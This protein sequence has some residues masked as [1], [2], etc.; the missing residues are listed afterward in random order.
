[1]IDAANGVVSESTDTIKANSDAW[2]KNAKAQ[3]AQ[4]ALTDIYK[5]QI[6]NKQQLDDVNKKLESS[7]KGWGAYV[8]DFPVVADEARCV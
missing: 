1:M 5:Q 3:A 7:E 6:K 4:E 2:I 8:G